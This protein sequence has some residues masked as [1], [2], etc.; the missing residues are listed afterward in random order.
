MTLGAGFLFFGGFVIHDTSLI[1]KFRPPGGKH[2]GI[3][4]R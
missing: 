4:G 1:H 3:M 2:S